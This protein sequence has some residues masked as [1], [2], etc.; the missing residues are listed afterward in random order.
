[1]NN[2]GV[3]ILLNQLKAAHGT[4]EQTMEGV[5]EEVAQYM[6]PGTANPIAG[7]YAHVVFSEDLFMHT[8]L[9]K[10]PPLM[11]T[12]FKDKTGASEV[13]PMD[14]QVAY[15]KWLKEVK[16][17]IKQFREY[18]KAVFAESEEYV[19]SLTDADLEKDVDMSAFGMGTRKTYDFIA[20]LISGHVYPIMGEI[21]VLKGIQGLKGFPF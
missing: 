11:E 5:T 18:A 4:L 1:M 8:F 20:N 19:A 6:P 21:S 13:Q 7:T 9:R 12:T 10:T 17:D 3:E 16:L 15:P 14:W 2:L